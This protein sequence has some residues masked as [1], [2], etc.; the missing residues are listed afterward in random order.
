MLQARGRAE[1]SAGGSPTLS[2]PKKLLFIFIVWTLAV[3]AAEA[4][5][6]VLWIRPPRVIS[7]SFWNPAYEIDPELGW[8][9]KRNFTWA[10]SIY[11]GHQVVV[12]TNSRGF[13]DREHDRDKNPGVRRVVVLGDSFAFGW[14]VGDG[15]TF[16][17]YL[18]KLAP[19]LEIINLGV[20]G[21]NLAQQRRLLELEAMD[22]SP[23][24]VLASFVQ[25]DV[26]S[27]GVPRGADLV[28]QEKEVTWRTL[29]DEH[30]Y[31]YSVVKTWTRSHRSVNKY[32]VQLGLR[33]PPGGY[34]ALD[35][36]L[37]PALKKYPEGMKRDWNAAM[38]ELLTMQ[39]LCRE[40]GV[41]FLVAS[42]P[43][44]QA[45]SPRAFA[46]TLADMVIYDPADFDLSKPYRML[47]EFCREHGIPCVNGYEGL[48]GAGEE[49]YM[50][51]DMHF[52]AKGHEAFARILV[53]PIRR[54][55]AK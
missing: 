25:N 50:P 20:A 22:Y 31:I 45:L 52:S 23:D 12:R 47:G 21:W 17:D 18:T 37:R 33:K 44:R 5:L 43:A 26:T 48:R 8:R 29:L 36:N 7:F 16:S 11:R 27:R 24:L 19:E 30:S 32:L 1:G 54:A 13:R 9:P 3:G 10:H 2:W 49:L 55:L 35:D 53:E 4:A 14:G 38:K 42:V 15:E 39:T 6:R 34:E 40:R 28:R 51:Y 41:R 46:A